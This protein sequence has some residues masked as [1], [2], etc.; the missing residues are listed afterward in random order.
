MD[1]LKSNLDT[2][3]LVERALDLSWWA[4]GS[5]AEMS[6]HASGGI[7]PH[8][9]PFK[10]AIEEIAML[11][12]LKPVHIMI[13]RVPSGIVVPRHTDKVRFDPD[14]R[15]HLPLITNPQCYW[16]DEGTEWSLYHMVVGYWHG[17]VPRK[18]YHQVMNNGKTDRIHLVV[19]LKKEEETLR[20]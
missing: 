18:M 17:P 4:D 7:P 3:S 1:R 11:R 10:D 2:A 20:E 9:F 14:E 13:N 6:F 5:G 12:Q 8:A 16:A 15:W 19:D